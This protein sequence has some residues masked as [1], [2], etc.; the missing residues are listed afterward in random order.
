MFR[1]FY[2]TVYYDS[3]YSVDFLSLYAKGYTGLLTDIDN[4][5]VMHGAPGNEESEAFFRK[6]SDIGWKT[7]VISNNDEARVAPFAR[8]CGCPYVCKAGKPKKNGYLKGMELMGTD[9]SNTVFMGDQMFTDIFGANNIGM[10]SI[11]V[12]PIHIDRVPYI[13]LKRAGEVIVKFFYRIY[14]RRHPQEL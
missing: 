12:K 14:S 10:K 3:A 9:L 6:L 7:C 13:L 2:P 5:L 8:S 4:T 11:L 1:K